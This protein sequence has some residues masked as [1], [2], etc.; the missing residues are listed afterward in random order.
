MVNF[1]KSIE[2]KY[3]REI[4][5]ECSLKEKCI[6]ECLR[7]YNNDEFV[8]KTEITQFQECIE[9]FDKK[10]RKKYLNNNKV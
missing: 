8:C 5:K 9:K 10:F 4:R 7:N 3:D 2:K 1:M 6:I